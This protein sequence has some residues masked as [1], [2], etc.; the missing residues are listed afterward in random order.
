MLPLVR[1][2]HQKLEDYRGVISGE[3]FQKI[4]EMAKDLRGLKVFQV[5]ATPRGG[6]VAEL[7]KSLVPLMKGI[8]IKTEWY[9]IPPREDFFK[10][11]K[12]IHNALQGKEYAIPFWQRVRYLEHIERSANLMRD[13]RPDIWVIHDPQPAGVILY[14]PHFHPAACRIHIDLTLPNPEAW[15]FFSGIFG[16]YDKIILS[17]KRF[18]KKEVKEKAVVFPPA[19]DPLAPKNQPLSLDFSREVLKSYGIDPLRPLVS[20][21][22]RFDPWKGFPELIEAYQIAKKRIPDLQL[23]LVGFFLAKDDPEAMKIYNLVKKKAERD[24]GILLFFDPEMLGSLKVHVFVNA[25]QVASKVVVQNSTR[26]GFG[27]SLTEAMWK[28][29]AV[30]GGPA[31]GIKLQI[32]NNKNG[33]L[34]SNPQGLAKRIIQLIKNPQFAEK[35]GK[36]AQK[37]VGEKFLIPRLLENYLKIFKELV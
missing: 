24:P 3:L 33:F 36:A 1:T 28:G 30:I 10:I 29:K 8:G 19:I 26:E 16:M 4:Q 12:E 22:S 14:L 27:L 35:L 32:Q 15:K 34:S 21:V 5:N 6:G 2:N 20:Q 23:A 18:I 13:M 31:E 17:S 11:T 9:T 37:T 7:L 25:I